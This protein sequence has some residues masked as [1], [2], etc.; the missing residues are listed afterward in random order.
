MVMTVYIYL[1]QI[2][3][4]MSIGDQILHDSFTHLQNFVEYQIAQTYTGT[5]D[6]SYKS[7]EKGL[8][9][10]DWLHAQKVK[11]PNYVVVIDK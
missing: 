11:E 3:E 7:V 5:A 10:L 8:Q 4:G 9:G 1:I 6:L 2:Y